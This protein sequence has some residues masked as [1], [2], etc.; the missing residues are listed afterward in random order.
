MDSDTHCLRGD[1]GRAV[2]GISATHPTYFHRM[3]KVFDR[4]ATGNCYCIV[5]VAVASVCCL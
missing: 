2:A 4:T 5:P 3:E 1:A